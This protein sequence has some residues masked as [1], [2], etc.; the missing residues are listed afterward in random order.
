MWGCWDIQAG[1][2]EED[3]G[4]LDAVGKVWTCRAEGETRACVIMLG[5]KVGGA[6]WEVL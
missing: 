5:E 3:R 4:S 1:I 6:C 2:E